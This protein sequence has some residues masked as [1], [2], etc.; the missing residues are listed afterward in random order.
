MLKAED[1]RS[2]IPIIMLSIKPPIEDSITGLNIG[3][4]DYI[5]KPFDPAE[6]VARVEVVLR[7]YGHSPISAGERS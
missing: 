3:T 2:P 5:G 6:L 7:G 4:G 1:Q